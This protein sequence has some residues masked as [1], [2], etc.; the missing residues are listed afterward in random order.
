MYGM[1]SPKKERKSSGDYSLST[2]YRQQAN[3]Q[4]KKNYTSH[5]DKR[6][7]WAKLSSMGSNK[8]SEMKGKGMEG[9]PER[10]QSGF[11]VDVSNASLLNSAKKRTSKNNNPYSGKKLN[12][13][14]KLVERIQGS[15]GIDSSKVSFLE[16]SE[17][18]KMGAK[19]TAQGDVSSE[20]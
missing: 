9:Q 3:Q 2:L 12:M 1:E 11:G 7:D 15:F 19:A 5:I 13:P 16:S 8:T 17:V 14:E 20:R 4:Q 6:V 10:F 18:A